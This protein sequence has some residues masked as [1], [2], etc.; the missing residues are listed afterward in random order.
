M[1]K[2]LH[3][4]LAGF[5]RRGPWNSLLTRPTDTSSPVVDCDGC[6][7]DFA[8]ESA[9]RCPGCRNLYCSQ[10]CLENNADFHLIY[11]KN[12]QRELTTAHKL[13]AA[14]FDDMF[15][16]DPQTNEDY[17]FNR[18][19]TT[20]DRIN[21]FGLYIGILK[22]DEVKPSTL[23]QWRISGTMVENIKGLFANIPPGARGGYYPWF[24]KN[25]DIF[26]P[27]P[28]AL[29]SLSP[30]HICASCGVSAS[31][32]CS[33]CRKVWYCSK[34]CQQKEWP[35]HLVDCDPKR[36]ITSADQL[37]AAAH[38]KKVPLD[39]ETQSD[40][41]FTRVDEVGGK[42][43]LDVYRVVFEEGVRPRDLHKW[44]TSGGLLKEMES[45][46]SGLADWKTCKFMQWFNTHR[47]AL[48][49]SLPVLQEKDSIV[50]RMQAAQV[51][52]WNT[53]G[54]FPSQNVDEIYSA[55]R[56]WPEQRRNF[57]LF[58]SL[59][60]LCH[61][62]PDM[63]Y[64]VPFGFC[65]CRD[66]D[67]EKFLM[68]TYQMLVEYCPYDEFFK[69]Y[70]ASSI[71][72]LLDGR[73]LRGRRMAL[74]YLEDVLSGSPRVFKSVWYLKQHVQDMNSVR[75]DMEPSVHADYGFMNC[76]SEEE[77]QDLRALYSTIFGRVDANPLKLHEACISGSLF[78]YVVGFVPELKKKKNKAKKLRRLLQNM[79][80]LANTSGIQIMF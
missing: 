62:G 70:D 67:E 30:R 20:E 57:F 3:T 56:D 17:F 15:P 12:P 25:L 24:I 80:P 71:T 41:G 79:Y 72:E 26:E 69:A 48:D 10:R 65:A 32:R 33:A 37:R 49:P 54:D 34:S 46:L 29:I 8:R 13:T 4:R 58:R 18:A 40:Y 42:V 31:V 19:R 75:S 45:L 6:S 23:H 22:H 73:G 51:E 9:V 38:R 11:C 66:E 47:F 74:P 64:W 28:S 27:R 50:S 16:D 76:T 36:P 77:Y 68:A 5:P 55:L 59:F 61:P 1:M 43:L 7:L 78:D 39:Q 60:G 53:V 21:L 2:A 14:A 44:K 52:L 35:G 63:D